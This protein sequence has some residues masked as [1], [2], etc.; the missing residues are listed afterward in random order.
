MQGADLRLAQMQGAGLSNAQ[1]QGAGL[2]NAQMQGADLWVAQMQGADLSGAQMQGADLSGAK[3]QGADLSRAEMQGVILGGTAIHSV[4]GEPKAAV[5]GPGKLFDAKMFSWSGLEKQAENIPYIYNRE[6]YLQRI[7]FAA[8]NARI[9][10]QN[11]RY[12]PTEITQAALPAI[13]QEKGVIISDEGR[14]AL[15][16]EDH[17]AAA[18]SFRRRYI[19]LRNN[20]WYGE[21]I[22]Q[23]PDYP[24]LLE[25]IDRKLCTLQ[26]C[27]DLRDKIDGLDCKNIPKPPG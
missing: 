21:E 18:Q 27:A 15:A 12:A 17:L 24:R 14:L 22:R 16:H 7:R 6:Q 4:R 2:S 20:P 3:M 23:N 9:A 8:Q 25:D 19:S 1:M 10:A 5:F 26:E 13:C 11:L